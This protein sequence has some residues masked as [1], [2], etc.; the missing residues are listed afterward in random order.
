MAETRKIPENLT[1]EELERLQNYG[2]IEFKSVRWPDWRVE[3][4]TPSR[5][6]H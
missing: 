3:K 4:L 5:T 6:Q 1:K 2:A